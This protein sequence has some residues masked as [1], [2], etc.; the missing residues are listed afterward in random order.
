M[1]ATF[2]APTGYPIP[3]L[4]Q[5]KTGRARQVLKILVD[6]YIRDGQPVGSRTLARD[7]DTPLSPAT[8]RNVM[9]DLED[10]G[11]IHAPHTSAGRVPTIR[12]YRV[13]IDSLLQIKPLDSAEVDALRQ[14]LARQAD[15]EKMLL[16]Q[17]SQ[18]VAQIT[19][20]AGIV[21][22]PKPTL[23]CL[24]HI[25]F[26]PL[27][28]NR[29]LAIL[30]VNAQEVQ[31][32][33]IYCSRPYS[34]E[35]LQEAANYLNQM[36]AGKSLEQ[37]R[38]E[39]HGQL[40]QAQAELGRQFPMVMEM[41]D[42]ALQPAVPTES[43]FYLTGQV[44]L[45]DA[46]ELSNI[47]KLRHLFA[48]LNRQQDILHLL[49][50]AV[51]ADGVQIFLG[52]ESGYDFFDQCSVVTAPYQV[53]GEVLGVLGVIGPTRIPYERVIPIVDVTAKL[54]GCALQRCLS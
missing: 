36:C 25:E 16:Q 53:D 8:I 5:D 34:A 39:L 10:M 38:T 21:M 18:L 50:Q 54:L 26:L 6:R 52:D 33:I 42:K 23:R 45:M 28:E 43:G 13:F 51:V 27:A 29:V 20:L 31:N 9:A 17:A 32:R 41:A 49:D 3:W 11:L 14:Q 22:I 12:G 7:M 30:V 37:A 24:R 4:D 1:S 35:A 48:A 19:H 15:N 44:N 2:N 47:E 40:R 46:E